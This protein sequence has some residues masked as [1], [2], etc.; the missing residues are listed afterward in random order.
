MD[1][2]TF[3]LFLSVVRS[4]SFSATARELNL[5][6]SS[7]SRQITQL[8]DELQTSLFVRTTRKLALTEAGHIFEERVKSILLDIDEAKLAVNDLDQNPKGTLRI[9]APRTLGR[10]HI[11]QAVLEYMDVWPEVKVEI[12]LSDLIVDLVA[13]DIDVAIRIGM[14]ND[15][16]MV[17]RRLGG[18][19]RYVYGS[20][21]Y[22][23]RMGIP[24]TPDDLKAHD[25]LTFHPYGL[26]PL[27]R[28]SSD[29]WRFEKEGTLS[30]VAVEGPLKTNMSEVII[31]AALAGKG[32]VMMLDWLIHDHVEA[33]RLQPV[34]QDYIAGP[35]SGDAAAFAVYPAGRN[36]PAK[37]RTFIDHLQD[38]FNRNLRV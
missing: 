17:A 31:Q 33:G 12:D 19:R 13:R 5:A 38:Y 20:P 24:T 36:A 37:V 35:Y 21:A 28:E 2:G 3:Q 4:G 14:L 10:L 16:S 23:D 1:I 22:F 32:L 8:E 27:W 26:S 29:L 30:E 6:P 11:V 18:V 15:S 9:T 7:V 25:C 34:L